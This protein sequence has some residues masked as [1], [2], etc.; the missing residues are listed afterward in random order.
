M[1]TSAWSDWSF[2][3]TFFCSQVSDPIPM[4]RSKHDD[5][6]S[7]TPLA[8]RA[9]Q[10]DWLQSLPTPNKVSVK[11]GEHVGDHDA[12][13][14]TWCHVKMNGLLSFADLSFICF[15]SSSSFLYQTHNQNGEKV[16]FSFCSPNFLVYVTKPQ[17]FAVTVQK[18]FKSA[19][20]D[21][22]WVWSLNSEWSVLFDL[23]S[24]LYSFILG[25]S[26]CWCLVE[27]WPAAWLQCAWGSPETGLFLLFI[28]PWLCLTALPLVTVFHRSLSHCW[29]MNAA[30]G[31][32]GL[33]LF[34]CCSPFFSESMMCSFLSSEGPVL[35][36]VFHMCGCRLSLWSLRNDFVPQSKE[37]TESSGLDSSF[38]LNES[39]QKSKCC[40][41][42]SRLFLLLTFVWRCETHNWQ[43][44]KNMWNQDTQHYL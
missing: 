12:R 37:R 15:R 27:Y 25:A 8:D 29:I 30:W 3:H 26:T 4:K 33:H 20:S 44:C 42:L 16:Q 9:K 19:T 40:I 28:Q 43:I 18:C 21:S 10:H 1:Q 32:L 38:S 5:L 6:S 24:T 39:N 2:K 36:Q 22:F 41:H 7:Q 31:K 11:S 14:D 17:M 13:H 34:R 23:R 35:F